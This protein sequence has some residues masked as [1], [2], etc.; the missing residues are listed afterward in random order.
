MRKCTSCLNTQWCPRSLK[1][2]RAAVT[3]A[4][5][6]ETF[7]VLPLLATLAALKGLTYM[8]VGHEQDCGIGS[9]SLR[10]S[11][12]VVN[13]APEFVVCCGDIV[14]GILHDGWTKLEKGG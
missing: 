7:E 12:S 9:R 11:R 2:R 10:R 13:G 14:N 1:G 4:V 3:I 5:N 6:S 8:L